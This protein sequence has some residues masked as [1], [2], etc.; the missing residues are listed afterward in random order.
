MGIGYRHAIVE[1]LAELGAKVYTCARNEVELS[2]C[3]VGWEDE[4]FGVVGSVCDVS[5][6]VN[7]CELIDN[8][9]AAFDG[10]LD[11]LVSL[12]LVNIVQC[13]KN[14]SVVNLHDPVR[15]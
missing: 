12:V 3:L 6:R 11:I 5:N 9:S 14:F 10:S 7:R 4:G 13:I 15:C 2:K 8:V 1:E